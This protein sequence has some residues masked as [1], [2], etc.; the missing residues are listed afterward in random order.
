MEKPN[1][2]LSAAFL[3]LFLATFAM[4]VAIACDETE[5][6]NLCR[7]SERFDPRTGLC[8]MPPLV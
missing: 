2:L 8:V 5:D 4:P 7:A 3:A 6:D 1:R